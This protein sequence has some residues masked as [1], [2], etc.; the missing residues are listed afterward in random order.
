[1]QGDGGLDNALVMILV[2]FA[3]AL[4][5]GGVPWEEFM[6]T[7]NTDWLLW[8]CFWQLIFGRF[9]SFVGVDAT[10]TSWNRCCCWTPSEILLFCTAALKFGEAKNHR[11]PKDSQGLPRWF[12]SV[13]GLGVHSQCR[14]SWRSIRQQVPRGSPVLPVG[15]P[16]LY[17][18][19]PSRSR[20]PFW[21]DIVGI[22][23]VPWDHSLVADN[24][25]DIFEDRGWSR[26]IFGHLPNF[27]RK[28]S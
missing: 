2:I 25:V 21:T 16:W 8:L 9:S 19:F 4:F 17:H 20:Y 12:S 11:T 1:M 22:L 14:G 28:K 7:I 26:W 18:G 15:S 3:G 5:G 6:A 27:I 10:A 24:F 23:S 13:Q